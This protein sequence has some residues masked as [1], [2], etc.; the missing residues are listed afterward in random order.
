MATQ[1]H[2]YER[3]SV[4]SQINACNETNHYQAR[5]CEILTV[6][7]MSRELFGKWVLICNVLSGVICVEVGFMHLMFR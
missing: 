2:K 5:K 7:T 1:Y 4:L 3:I 6:R